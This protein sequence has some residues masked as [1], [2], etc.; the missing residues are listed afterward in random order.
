MIT[1]A[2]SAMTRDYMTVAL[3]GDFFFSGKSWFW[4]MGRIVHDVLASFGIQ[5][6]E[7]AEVRKGDV[8]G[9]SGMTGGVTG[10]HLHWGTRV[11]GTRVDPV[12]LIEKQRGKGETAIGADAKSRK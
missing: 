3:I 4:I 7:G 8:I 11:N 1:A 2:A 12:E 9:L 5:M 6:E 10:P